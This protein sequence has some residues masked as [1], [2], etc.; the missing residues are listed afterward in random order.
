M[1][2]NLNKQ[3][4]PN[5]MTQ[6]EVLEVIRRVEQK[7]GSFAALKPSDRSPLTPAYHETKRQLA[8]DDAHRG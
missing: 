3:V 1:I 8:K 4:N 7:Y 2:L 6:E 5:E